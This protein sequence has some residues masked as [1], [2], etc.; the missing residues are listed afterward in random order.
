MRYELAIFDMDGTIL[1]TLEDLTE[2]TNYALKINNFPTHTIDEIRTFV[3]NGIRRLI[4]RAVP[5][6]TLTDSINAVFDTFTTYY[7][8]HCADKTQPYEGIIT[9]LNNLREQGC[10]IAVVSNKAHEAVQTLCDQYFNDLFDYAVGERPGI[11]K[12]PA[13]DS[14]NEV[15]HHLQIKT[16]HAVYIGDSEVDIQTADNALMDSIIVSWGFREVSFLKEQGAK[17]IVSTTDEIEKIILG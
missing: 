11:A 13:P 15:L 9:L 12:K 4:E 14:V 17:T 16:E 7:K 2:A 6:D 10:K 1:N 5:K 3:G 8:E